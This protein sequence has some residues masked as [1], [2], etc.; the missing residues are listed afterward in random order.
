MSE[1][2]NEQSPPGANTPDATPV[3]YLSALQA[4]QKRLVDTESALRESHSAFVVSRKQADELGKLVERLAE[5]VTTVARP[6]A[7]GAGPDKIPVAPGSK[8]WKPPKWSGDAEAFP[9]YIT[10]LTQSYRARAALYPP[11]SANIYWNAIYETI[12]DV[13]KRQRLRHYWLEGAEA[14]EKD[15]AKF[16]M[17]IEK[18]FGDS[19]EQGKALEELVSLRHEPGQPWR[20]HQREFD[21]LLLTS[22]GDRFPDRVKIAHLKKTF[23]NPVK[24]SLVSMPKEENYA[25]FVE[26]VDGYM[27][28]YE[29]TDQFRRAYKSWKAR[30]LDSGRS[31]PGHYDLGPGPV[32]A[33]P[34]TDGDGDTVMTATLAKHQG[35]R[36]RG[37][38]ARSAKAGKPDEA[39]KKRAKWVDRA[40]L[41]RRR[42]KGLCFRCGDSGHRASDCPYL[43]AKRPSVNVSVVTTE[44]HEAMLESDGEDS[45]S[46]EE[47][48]E[49]E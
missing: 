48:S 13:N 25:K 3:D 27:T 45:Q 36:R 44:K 22:G 18:V 49:N 41:D 34:K 37:Y 47:D 16:I 6:V 17:E 19:N 21:G 32:P 8:D 15:P 43:G 23:S 5:V 26:T 30:N 12:Q 31:E 14:D 2:S 28:N 1:S 10:R 20:D 24:L 7:G 29:E 35:Q 38:G 39:G 33:P 4:M 11:L 40:E 9:D 46:N 42:E